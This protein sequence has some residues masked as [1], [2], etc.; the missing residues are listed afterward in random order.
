MDQNM[1]GAWILMYIESNFPGG[2]ARFTSDGGIVIGLSDGTVV[3]YH[4]EMPVSFAEDITKKLEGI[5]VIV[6]SDVNAIT[7]TM[8]RLSQI[9]ES[10]TPTV[11]KMKPERR[12]ITDDD[13]TDLKITL[14]M[15]VDEF[16]NNM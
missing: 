6:T 5:D 13:I 1:L 10:K 7:E 8:K 11:I 9:D 15:G 16:I 4:P 12:I 2:T 3:I 14:E